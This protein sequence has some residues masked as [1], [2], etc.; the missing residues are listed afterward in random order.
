M[1][2]FLESGQNTEPIVTVVMPVFNGGSDLLLAVQSI[3]QQTFLN[4]ELL[5]LDDG[6]TD[7][8]IERILTLNDPRIIVLQ[9]GQNKGIS[10]RLNQAIDMARGRYFARMDH[11]D[12]S[13]PNRLVLQVAFLE[14][15]EQVDLVATKCVKINEL[16]QGLGTLPFASEHKDIC[17][18]PWIGFPM[19]HPSWM[20]RI[21]WFRSHYY[22]S[23]GPY[24]CEDNE[25]L[26]RAHKA[27]VYHALETTLLA[28]RVRNHTPWQKLWKTRK[29]MVRMQLNFFLREREFINAALSCIAVLVKLM[30]D[31]KNELSYRFGFSSAKRTKELFCIEWIG[32]I[33]HKN[34][35]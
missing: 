20:G 33:D 31:L 5:I 23:T 4:W 10:A 28:Y 26:L 34:G 11:D 17:A 15:H 16:H 32:K 2:K 14:K 6:S 7:S 27:S 21:S 18:R 19:P 9:D 12:V 13:H 35:Q 22:L 3:L 1:N 8:A 29:A 24:C 30:R 25:L